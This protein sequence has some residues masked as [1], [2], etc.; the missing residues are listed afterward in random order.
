MVGLLAIII[1]SLIQTADGKEIVYYRVFFKIRFN[2]LSGSGSLRSFVLFIKHISFLH[3]SEPHQVPRERERRKEG[4]YS[5]L[6]LFSF[7]WNKLDINQVICYCRSSVP[8]LGAET[9]SERLFQLCGPNNCPLCHLAG[10]SL[11]DRRLRSSLP[12]ITHF[13]QRL[14]PDSITDLS[15][16]SCSSFTGLPVVTWRRRRRRWRRW[17][18]R[19]VVILDSFTHFRPTP[20]ALSS[21]QKLSFLLIPLTEVICTVHLLVSINRRLALLKQLLKSSQQ[22]SFW[23]PIRLLHPR[24]LQECYFIWI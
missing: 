7:L 12:L 4:G 14:S 23:T 15:L 3:L 11:L 24:C 1:F 17:R 6:R 16:Y 22:I 2:L 5:E 19:D 8:D 21:P 18:R 9:T 13:L 20:D 10:F